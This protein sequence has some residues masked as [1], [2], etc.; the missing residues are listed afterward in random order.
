LV[1]RDDVGLTEYADVPDAFLE[2]MRAVCLG[3]P[4][5]YEEQ[6]WTGR[7]WMV[8][9]RNFAHVFTVDGPRGPATVVQFRSNEP[10]RSAILG[11]GHPFFPGQ[12]G[13]NVVGMV[14][15]GRTD[16]DEVAELMTE[17]YCILAPRK[18]VEQ[19]DRPE[20]PDAGAGD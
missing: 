9:R 3:L 18:L 16:W 7:R 12:W 10:E 19:V 15:D 5:A 4:D 17:S 2:G 6:A 14:L 13:T 11:T 1:G 20:L 8:R